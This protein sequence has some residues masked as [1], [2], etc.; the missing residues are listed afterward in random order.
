VVEECDQFTE[1]FASQ[2]DGT[3][4]FPGATCTTLSRGYPCG[5]DDFTSAGKWV[6]EAEYT[7][8]CAPGQPIGTHGCK[9][10]FTA[11]CAAVA[12]P[13]APNTANGFSA[14]KFQLELNAKTFFPCT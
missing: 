11:F 1:C 10:T 14:V 3:T 6:G 2:N 12:T 9:Q 13:P 7:Y 5:W 8:P 4:P